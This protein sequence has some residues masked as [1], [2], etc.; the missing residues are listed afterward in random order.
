MKRIIF[1]VPRWHVFLHRDA[2]GLE[3]TRG[4][5]DDAV[6]KFADELFDRI[7]SDDSER[8]SEADQDRTLKAWA[9][10]VHDACTKLPAFTRLA[11]E[12]RGEAYAAGTAVETLMAVL[13]PQVPDA[14]DQ[15]PP[16]T[17]RRSI[18]A[19]CEKASQAVEE[20]RDSLE[21]LGQ[22]GWG[23]N[24]G[25]GGE[26]NASSIRALAGRLKTDARLRQI[27]ML[28]GRFKRIAAAKRRQKYRHGADEIADIEQGADLARLLPSEVVKL[29]HPKLRLAFMRTVVERSCL[30]YQLIGNAP[31]GRGPLVVLLDK[32]GSM[33]GPRDIWATAVALAL[34]DHAHREGRTFALL[35]FDYHVKHES[36]VK[37]GGLLPQEALFTACAGG[38]EI[39]AAVARGLELIRQ[40]QELRKGDLVVITDG[41]SDTASAPHLRAAASMI[42]VSV[43]G[44]GIGVEAP[45]LEPWCDEVQAIT[46]LTS[47]DDSTADALFAA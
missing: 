38:T 47:I 8:L 27:A 34:L 10:G 17:I 32:S 44:V 41:G 31:L 35:A 9:D 28:A 24:S 25:V 20:L 14:P 11:A 22:V 15:K 1:D 23:T 21:G 13:K 2:R 46:S 4:E 7:Y 26:L 36:V 12:C 33:D 6:L 45:W 39:G 37:P 30:Q 40:H 3:A 19:A 16:E 5:R 18:G 43:L 42:G 29:T